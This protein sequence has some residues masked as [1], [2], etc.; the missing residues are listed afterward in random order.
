MVKEITKSIRPL[1]LLALGALATN[2]HAHQL[3]EYLQSTIVTIEPHEFHFSINLSPG[4]AIA[5]QLITHIDTNHDGTIS[6]NE[7]NN[8][9]AQFQREIT[10]TL[11]KQPL[12]IKLAASNFPDL[13]ELTNGFGMIQLEFAATSIDLQLGTHQLRIA[14]QHFPKISAYLV[15]AAKPKSPQIQILS[16][17]R[18]K[19]QSTATIAFTYKPPLTRS[20]KITTLAIL[21]VCYCVMFSTVWQRQKRQ[22]AKSNKQQT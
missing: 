8:Y 11:D 13:S 12:S 2:A 4:V 9:C 7:S 10:V 16:Q 5:N 6:S 18:N 20:K 17:T 21:G 1:I 14:N 3:D 19:T 15:N 22:A